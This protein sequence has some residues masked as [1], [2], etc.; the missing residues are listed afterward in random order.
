MV[1]GL[2]ARLE[3][4]ADMGQALCGK[5]AVLIIPNDES[6][7][8][9]LC[10][11]LNAAPMTEIYRALFGCRSLGK[12]SLSIGPRQ[13]AQ[14]PVP[15]GMQP[16]NPCGELVGRLQLAG[17][18]LHELDRDDPQRRTLQFELDE[19]VRDALMRSGQVS[20]TSCALVGTR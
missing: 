15:H 2:A 18:A 10:A 8:H 4:V 12:G 9:A 5:S 7:V 19:L 16:G 11:W 6:V 3:A 1:A 14:L 17:S 20:P 13:L